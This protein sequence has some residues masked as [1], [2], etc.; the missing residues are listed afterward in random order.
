MSL[1][2]HRS[3]SGVERWL[4]MAVLTAALPICGG[5]NRTAPAAA[6][7]PVA[8]VT[9][10]PVQSEETVDADE[11]T[12]KT[13]ASEIVEVRARV[14]GFIKTVDFTDGKFVE[15]GKPLFT[16][17]P[18]EYQAIHKQSQSRVTLQESKRDLAKA[19][20]ARN[21][22]LV[23]RQAV[24]QQ[25]Y[26]ESVAAFREATAAIAVAEA[27][28]AKTALDVKYTVVTAPIGGRIDRALVTRG[29]LVTGGLGSGTLLTKI[30]NEQPMHVY[31]D[32]DERSLLRYL[33]GRDQTNTTTP[34]SLKDLKMSC[35]IQLA[36]E[37]DFPHSGIL[38]FAASEVESGTGTARIR[39]VVENK[40]RALA[41][42]LRVRVRIPIGKPYQALLIPEQALLTDQSIKFVYV[43]G[44]DGAATRRTVELGRQK[45]DMRIIRSGLNVGDRVVVKGQQRV[46]PGQK[47]EAELQQQPA[48]A[49]APTATATAN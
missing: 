16:I 3:R 48:P 21:E 24:S 36:D 25:E 1:R 23:Q 40:D 17:E 2:R 33:R 19:T 15:E 8:K 46:R 39:A 38:D 4:I 5:C 22:A 14:S 20:L 41:S 47:V 7:Q 26:E 10:I 49:T 6:E 37:K 28:A 11:Y 32:V 42:G 9:V 45:G 12:G 31:F 30:V 34:G 43:V 35:S 13:E 27:D 44:N 29:N 18:D